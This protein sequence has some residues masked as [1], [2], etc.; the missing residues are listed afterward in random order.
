MREGLARLESGQEDKSVGEAN[1]ALFADAF[2]RWLGLLE[3][4]TQALISGASPVM[5]TTFTDVISEEAPLHDT[6]LPLPCKEI[7]VG[8]V[9]RCIFGNTQGSKVWMVVGDS[10]AKMFTDAFYGRIRQF[11]SNIRIEQYV[12]YSCPNSL[13]ET[14]LQT[15]QKIKNPKKYAACLEAHRLEVE[16]IKENRPEVIIFSDY[17]ASSPTEAYGSGLQAFLKVAKENASHVV[18][19]SQTPIWP[20]LT[21]CLGRNLNSFMACSGSMSEVI[22][23]VSEQKRVARLTGAQ[24]ISMEE[25]LCVGKVCPVVIDGTPVTFDGGRSAHITRQIAEA[26]GP[27]L[28]DR[29]S[30]SI[31]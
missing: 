21:D 14:G 30:K 19:L 27:A 22:R 13:L 28:L 1:P 11:D 26:L 4:S 20:K 3:E 12:S 5:T 16:A 17:A 6:R 25:M 18:L 29:I 23:L 10:H 15:G 7:G 31:E 8:L 2:A 24:F 9:E